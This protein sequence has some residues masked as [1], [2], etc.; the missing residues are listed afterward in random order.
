MRDNFAELANEVNQHFS[1]T[2]KD[3]V[4]DIGSNDGNLLSNFKKQCRILGITPE[5]IAKIAIKKGIPTIQDY[6]SKNLSLK[7][8]KKYGKAKIITAT[9]VFA[10][11]DNIPHF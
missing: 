1:L 5:N 6:F 3:L 8:E 4:I 10:H 7:I 9:N 11:M 2:D